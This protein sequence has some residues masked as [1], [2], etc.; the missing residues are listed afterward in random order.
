MAGLAACDFAQLI[1][2]VR[3]V[4]S[5]WGAA[6]HHQI[7]LI[8][9]CVRGLSQVVSTPGPAGC[10]FEASCGRLPDTARRT[11]W[12]LLEGRLEVPP[13]PAV[14]TC[15]GAS[16]AALPILSTETAASVFPTGEC[17]KWWLPARGN[18]PRRM[19]PLFRRPGSRTCERGLPNSA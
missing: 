2:G 5:V 10:E 9:Q 8:C 15:R 17:V 12:H 18:V 3:V 4:T 19:S 7:R 13:P 14:V 11:Y 6:H 1:Q 16:S